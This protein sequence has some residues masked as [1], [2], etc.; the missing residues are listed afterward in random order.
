M[1]KTRGFYDL[2]LQ[3][4]LFHEEELEQSLKLL[5]DFG[6]RTIAVNQMIDDGRIENNKKK[7]KKKGEP[8][9]PLD[10]VPIPFDLKQIQETANKLNLSNFTVLNRLT[11]SFANQESL[12]KITK[13]PNYKKF[14]IIAA[15]PTAHQAFAFTCGSFEADIFTFNPENKFDLR[16]NRKFYNQLIDRG[17]HLELQYSYAIN[18]S[19]SRKNM[20]HAAHLFY[21]FGKSKKI[22]FSSGADSLM[23]IRS[24]YD[25]VNLAFIFGLS[26]QKCKSAVSDCPNRVVIN[27]VGRRHGKSVMFVENIDKETGRDNMSIENSEEEK[28]MEKDQPK[29]K[30]TKI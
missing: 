8:R 30:K 25:I 6:Y 15:A 24:P 17:Y 22:I 4:S 29:Q 2:C 20:I 13:S 16:L 3:E 7:K 11:V 18:D 21:M 28:E 23:H 27:S 26:E 12:H 5:Y 1:I 14:H 9:E 10:I 19:T